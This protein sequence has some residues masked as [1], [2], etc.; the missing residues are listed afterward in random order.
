MKTKLNKMLN[1]ELNLKQVQTS[2][3]LL[4]GKVALTRSDTGSLLNICSDQY[5]PFYNNDLLCLVRKIENI[6]SL[7]V[8]DLACGKG[9]TLAII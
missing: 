7:N 2:N 9:F 4:R 1:W 5:R 3:E 6:S 8:I